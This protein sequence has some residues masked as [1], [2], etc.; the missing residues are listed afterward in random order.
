ME[1]TENFILEGSGYFE[2]S[3]DGIL[4]YDDHL[5][6]TYVDEFGYMV[7]VKCEKN[8]MKCCS[9][10]TSES[11]SYYYCCKRKDLVSSDIVIAISAVAVMLF[12]LA[13]VCFV[14]CVLSVPV[15]YERIRRGNRTQSEF[16]NNLE[17]Q[18]LHTRDEF[19]TSTSDSPTETN[20]H[21]G[22]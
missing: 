3:T 10:S 9:S 5:V 7:E 6:C 12:I 1:G 21:F 14:Y 20:H 19:L 15:W 8:T 11:I 4:E 16:A 17:L 13:S 22:G 2:Y 18:S